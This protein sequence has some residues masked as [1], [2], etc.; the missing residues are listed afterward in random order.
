MQETILKGWAAFYKP[1]YSPIDK[2]LTVPAT[3]EQI[4][5]EIKATREQ[6]GTPS[7]KETAKEH[8]SNILKI[9]QK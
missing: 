3:Q 9:F 7:S 8:I 4:N 5:A 1:N 2:T 6:K